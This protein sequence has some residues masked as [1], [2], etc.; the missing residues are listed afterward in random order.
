MRS[1]KYSV[2]KYNFKKNSYYGSIV[3]RGENDLKEIIEKDNQPKKLSEL[4]ENLDE[5]IINHLREG[6]AINIADYVTLSPTLKGLFDSKDDR[7]DPDRHNIEII[8]EPGSK[9]KKLVKEKNF[10]TKK[11]ASLRE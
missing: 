2:E 4:I 11:V 9:L 8:A 3:V 10:K 7:F 1:L 6:Y 5:I